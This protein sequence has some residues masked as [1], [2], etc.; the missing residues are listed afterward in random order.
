MAYHRILFLFFSRSDI[1]SILRGWMPL[2]FQLLLLQ[3]QTEAHCFLYTAIC[4]PVLCHT[5]WHRDDWKHLY[6]LWRWWLGRKGS[7][8]IFS[9][10][11]SWQMMMGLYRE[12]KNEYSLP[13]KILTLDL[14]HGLEAYILTP[15]HQGTVAAACLGN[16]FE[17]WCVCRLHSNIFCNFFSHI[18]SL[19]TKHPLSLVMCCQKTY[20]W[21]T[22]L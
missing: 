3:L 17:F 11:L 9:L 6:G 18:Y 4:V 13:L 2:V 8:L 21:D 20:F 16:H 15:N 1:G 7:W 12:R 5:H 14:C 19:V 10:S 22:C